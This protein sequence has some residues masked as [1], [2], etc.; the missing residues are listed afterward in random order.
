MA[1][2][3]SELPLLLRYHASCVFALWGASYIC[4]WGRVA[5]FYTGMAY[6]RYR[7]T[8]MSMA[9]VNR[10]SRCSHKP[11]SV[12]EVSEWFVYD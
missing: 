1:Q 7:Q 5:T 6:V 2:V 4:M 10:Q 3:A 9:S 11:I 8:C 12:L